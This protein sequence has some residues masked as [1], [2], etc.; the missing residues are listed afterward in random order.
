MS[1]FAIERRGGIAI[2]T[3]DTP[4][5]AVNK[6]SKAIGW[7]LEEL[8]QRLDADEVVKAIVLRIDSPGGT[9]SASVGTSGR[10]GVRLA[11]VTARAL[12]WPLRTSCSTCGRLDT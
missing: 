2:V 12:S 11:F 8:L 3:F 5:D 7:E 1:A 10:S 9:V 6:I 4:H